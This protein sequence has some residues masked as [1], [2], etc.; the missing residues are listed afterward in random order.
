MREALKRVKIEFIIEA[1]LVIVI[2]II[3][4]GWAPVVIPVMARM[5]AVLLV[6][7]GVVFIIAFIMKKYK[8]PFSFSVLNHEWNKRFNNIILLSGNIFNI[9]KT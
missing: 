6:L 4:L 5:L 7:I 9:R 2:G 3:L 1:I 8:T